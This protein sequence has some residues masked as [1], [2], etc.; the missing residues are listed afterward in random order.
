MARI[1]KRSMPRKLVLYT[2]RVLAR[3]VNFGGATFISSQSNCVVNLTWG[4]PLT[5]KTNTSIYLT[6]TLPA[7][8]LIK[9]KV[10]SIAREHYCLRC[11]YTRSGFLMSD[12]IPCIWLSMQAAR[13]DRNTN[14]AQ[15]ATRACHA[16]LP[17]SEQIN[18]SP[19]FS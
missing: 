1:V 3:V 14:T 2:R 18:N 12:S 16:A 9:V 13:A 17:Q 7:K 8:V 10:T 19:K 11:G 6:H 5:A 4:R 15:I